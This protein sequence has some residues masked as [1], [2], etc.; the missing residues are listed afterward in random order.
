MIIKQINDH[1]R[2]LDEKFDCEPKTVKNKVKRIDASLSNKESLSQ[3]FVNSFEIEGFT[4]S[5][6]KGSIITDTSCVLLFSIP[7]DKGWSAKVNGKESRIYKVNAS[8]IGIPLSKGE[9]YV[10]LRYLPP[11]FRFGLILSVIALIII[12]RNWLIRKKKSLTKYFLKR[13]KR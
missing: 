12:L 9:S 5:R 13:R 2:F 6:I 8:F 11:Y 7:F 10:E 4:Q 1:E 3:N